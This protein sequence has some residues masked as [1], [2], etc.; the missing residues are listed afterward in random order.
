MRKLVLAGL[1]AAGV[2]AAGFTARRSTPPA[3]QFAT[4]AEVNAVV[5]QRLH[6]ILQQKIAEARSWAAPT[7]EQTR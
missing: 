1:L 7:G 6:Q 2:V 4:Q 3:E 5:D